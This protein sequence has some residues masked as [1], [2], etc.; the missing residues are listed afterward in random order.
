MAF[1]RMTLQ[2]KFTLFQANKN[3]LFTLINVFLNIWIVDGQVVCFI[4]V[5]S[6]EFY[7]CCHE[8]DGPGRVL[9][10]GKKIFNTQIFYE[11]EMCSQFINVFRLWKL[12]GGD[13]GEGMQ[14]CMWILNISEP[15]T[16]KIRIGKELCG[17]FSKMF[18]KI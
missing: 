8:C 6:A 10:K 9:R 4:S 3:A 14:L 17:F 7:S 15:A 13:I 5:C 2:H 12:E 1:R 11:S 16:L 18:A